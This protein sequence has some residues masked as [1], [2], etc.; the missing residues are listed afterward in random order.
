MVLSSNDVRT[1]FAEAGDMETRLLR[2]LAEHGVSSTRDIS[3][4]CFHG[5]VK[6]S[7]MHELL[8]RLIDEEKIVARRKPSTGRPGRLG[9]LWELVQR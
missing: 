4:D 9:V 2:Y 5:N 3:R 6:A 7:E 1:L 8:G